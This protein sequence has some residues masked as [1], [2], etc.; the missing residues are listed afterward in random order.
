[1]CM[2]V[3]NTRTLIRYFHLFMQE[4]MFLSESLLKVCRGCPEGIQVQFTSVLYFQLLLLLMAVQFTS[5][6]TYLAT[7]KGDTAT[8]GR[9]K[10]LAI[11]YPSKEK[12]LNTIPSAPLLQA[13]TQHC[14]SL[15][16]HV[17]LSS[18]L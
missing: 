11:R 14:T 10:C 18:S 13:S 5:T 16:S 17:C 3:Q 7:R 1:M 4:S 9:P 8:D 15:F 6:T 12:R 2:C